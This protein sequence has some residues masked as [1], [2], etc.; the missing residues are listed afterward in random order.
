METLDRNV[1]VY[2]TG[3]DYK[4][5]RILRNLILLHSK[6]GKGY[7]FHLITPSNLESYVQELPQNFYDLI[8]A[9][10]A[11][12][13]RV[14]VIC[15]N[16][17]IWLDSDTL[18]VE[19][20]DSLFDILDE[21][22]GFLIRENNQVLC[23]GVF[24]SRENTDFMKEWKFRSMKLLSSR[25]GNLDWTEIGSAL[26]KDIHNSNPNILNNYELFNGLDNLYPVNWNNCVSEFLHRSYDNYKNIEKQYQPIVLLVNSVYKEVESWTMSEIFYKQTPLSY[27]LHKSINNLNLS[28]L[29]FIEI[30]TSNFDTLIEHCEHEAGIIVEPVK[31]YL[32]LL[33][34]KKNVNKINKAVSN[35]NEKVKI[36]YIP[37]DVIEANKLP[38]WL[39]GCNS[40]N[41]YH[42]LHTKHKLEHFCK[43]EEVEVIKTS[44]LFYQNGVGKVKFLKID[45]EGH[46]CVILK[47]LW[48]YLRH[49]PKSFYPDKIKFESNENSNRSEVVEVI[50]NFKSIG[51]ELV[52]SG[53][54]TVLQ[55]KTMG[56]LS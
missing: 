14:S 43:A 13:I 1:Y 8:P 47:D 51:Y 55:Y 18:V 25:K 37:E 52:S 49:L 34:A 54:D 45:T 12:F 33:P 27:F 50:E 53:Y 36:Y 2:W 11:D 41:N 39:K 4:L 5:I 10:Q 20:L 40:I 32:D 7:N 9:H 17:G 6:S 29:D 46:D 15:D 42:P 31:Y 38:S 23:N 35:K 56:N 19:S 22:E 16:G 30:G 28:D 44:E 48:D 21:K 3:N 26:M 24:G